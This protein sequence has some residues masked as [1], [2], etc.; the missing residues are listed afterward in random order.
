M[1]SLTDVYASKSI[2]ISDRF[3]NENV[4]SEE[5]FIGNR[6]KF[7]YITY[8]YFDLSSLEKSYKISSAKLILFKSRNEQQCC[9]NDYVKDKNYGIYILKEHFSGLTNYNN[10]PRYYSAQ[11]VNFIS[12]PNQIYDE[13]DINNIVQLWQDNIFD[14]KGIML[15]G[16]TMESKPLIYGAT[17]NNDT[18]LKPF[19]RVNYSKDEV[20]PPH[21]ELEC[22]YQILPSVSDEP[23]K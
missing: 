2:T 15:S 12:N 19:L 18:T 6:N 22:K 20:F 16:N 8:L 11:G 5:V 17:K 3:P 13:I 1:M 4:N 10:K 14:N 9:N 23:K 7:R 21:V